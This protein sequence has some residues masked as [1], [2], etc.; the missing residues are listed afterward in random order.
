MEAADAQADRLVLVSLPT[1]SIERRAVLAITLTDVHWH[2][3]GRTQVT[4]VVVT[5]NGE[6]IEL[7]WATE[8]VVAVREA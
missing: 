6:R 4:G 3:E 8:I 1:V 2:E 5:I 7:P